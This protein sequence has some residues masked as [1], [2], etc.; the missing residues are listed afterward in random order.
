MG[1]VLAMALVGIVLVGDNNRKLD[2]KC[3][4]EVIDGIA[5]SH[6]ECRNYYIQEKR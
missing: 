5:E 3:A 6:Q 4:Q 2:E 1:M